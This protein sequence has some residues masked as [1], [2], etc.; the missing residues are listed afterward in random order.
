[1][2]IVFVT[3]RVSDSIW[4]LQN[5]GASL[6]IVSLQVIFRS[7][8]SNSWSHFIPSFKGEIKLLRRTNLLEQ[9]N[10]WTCTTQ[11]SSHLKR[12]RYTHRGHCLFWELKLTSLKRVSI[13]YIAF[14]ISAWFCTIS[15]TLCNPLSPHDALKHHFTSPKTYLIFLQQSVLERKL[16]CLNS[17]AN[18]FTNTW[19]FSLISLMTMVNSGFKWLKYPSLW[20]NYIVHPAA[21]QWWFYAGITCIKPALDQHWSNVPCLP[22]YRQYKMYRNC[23]PFMYSSNKTFLCPIILFTMRNLPTSPV[24]YIWWDLFSGWLCL[25]FSTHPLAADTWMNCAYTVLQWQKTVTAFF[26]S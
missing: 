19:Q 9:T 20:P 10:Q 8:N 1:M 15:I 14:R 16:P 2:W 18:C 13:E 7:S 11:L 22:V 25:M 21:D 4:D 23:L 24:S 17:L 3:K 12:S 6:Y 5:G 26:S